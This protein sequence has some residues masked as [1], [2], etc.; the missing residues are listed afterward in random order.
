MDCD[1]ENC[2][3]DKDDSDDAEDD[4][5][6][7]DDNSVDNDSKQ[8]YDTYKHQVMFLQVM[9]QVMFFTRFSSVIFNDIQ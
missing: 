6:G 2:D 8:S 7:D 9:F 3:D 1:E 4:N 5:D